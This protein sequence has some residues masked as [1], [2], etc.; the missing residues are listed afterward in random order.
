MKVT[1]YAL[2]MTVAIA[3]YIEIISPLQVRSKFSNGLILTSIGSFGYPRYGQDFVGTLVFPS[4]SDY[5][6]YSINVD[7]S[8]V[9]N[10][11][12]VFTRGRCRFVEFA[13]IAQDAGAK[14]VI[15][16]NA[17]NDDISEKIMISNQD[18]DYVQV[19]AML[20][21]QDDG[22]ILKANSSSSITMKI[23]LPVPHVSSVIL[24]LKL[25]GN[26]SKDVSMINS[27]NT[28][29]SKLEP[30]H[31]TIDIDY[32]IN[33]C[34]SCKRDN[35]SKV[36]DDC[37]AGGRYCI[38]DNESEVKGSDM[39][40]DLLRNYCALRTTDSTS[41][42][43]SLFAY[44]QVLYS[45]CINSYNS[46]CVTDALGA[47]FDIS[48][49]NDCISES[50]IGDDIYLDD[51]SI[52]YAELLESS[53][54]SGVYPTFTV[55]SLNY[56][57]SFKTEISSYIVCNN[58]STDEVSY[59]SNYSSINYDSFLPQEESTDCAPGC[60]SSMLGNSLC[61]EVCNN[62]D[63]KFDSGDCATCTDGCYLSMLENGE[64]DL[65][66]EVADCSY[67][68]VDCTH[69]EC[70]E[71][72]LGDGICDLD[73]YNTNCNH[74]NGDCDSCAEGCPISY[75]ND[76]KCDDVCMVEECGYDS[77][78]C[79]VCTCAV[80]MMGDGVCDEDC[81][82]LECAYDMGDCT[83][84][85]EDEDSEEDYDYDYDLDIDYKEDSTGQ[86]NSGWIYVKW[87]VV[88]GSG[89]GSIAVM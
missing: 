72:R 76:G 54:Y 67:D 65:E 19:F 34:T 4:Y 62:Y 35:Y 55:N 46:V 74:D 84:E 88:M 2:L 1:L 30:D 33:I 44:Y 31:I 59:C 9:S 75:L 12:V 52:L 8:D 86:T 60:T 80:N 85:P 83:Y 25:T 77:N 81:N 57:G 78:D 18:N 29:I 11:V 7:Y 48:K 39:L 37:L 24:E 66:C 43:S 45:A 71:D 56:R 61:E 40:Y 3:E 27:L 73:C 89:F 26:R 10:A 38:V 70:E 79:Y 41:K 28:L 14:A 53:S 47:Y 15:I 22:T 42:Y 69:C 5:N 21:N 50:I 63:C 87:A 82:N 32:N 49:I 16:I 64:C 68:T 36:R 23:Y 58:L 6:C 17:N 13:K 20:I 51:N